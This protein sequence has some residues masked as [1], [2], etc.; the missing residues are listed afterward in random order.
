MN[1]VHFTFLLLALLGFGASAQTQ[2]NSARLTPLDA[3][4]GLELGAPLPKNVAI[5]EPLKSHEVTVVPPASM[6]T[7]PKCV[8]FLNTNDTLIAAIEATGIV[9]E[10]EDAL[11]IFNSLSYNFSKRCGKPDVLLNQTTQKLHKWEKE[12]HNLIVGLRESYGALSGKKSIFWIDLEL[13]DKKLEPPKD[14]GA[15]ERESERKL[16]KTP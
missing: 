16:R 5:V 14:G 3:M 6:Q 12:S 9:N 2:T 8:V 10:E 4:F 15:R 11:R 1:R 13:V 7:F